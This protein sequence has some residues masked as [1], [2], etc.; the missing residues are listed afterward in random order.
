LAPS[1][2]ES[3][4]LGT[5]KSFNFEGWRQFVELA[6]AD[7]KHSVQAKRSLANTHLQYEL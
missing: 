6:A 7:K 4:I 5:A 1:L 3:S 2:A